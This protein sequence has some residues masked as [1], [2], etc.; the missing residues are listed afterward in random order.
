[1]L[2]Y[3][4]PDIN[5]KQKP[6]KTRTPAFPSVAKFLVFYDLLFSPYAFRLR[7]LVVKKTPAK[8]Q[9]AIP[10]LKGIMGLKNLVSVIFEHQ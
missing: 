6:K 8:N 2:K 4:L 7:A 9:L 3:I 1:L 10:Q 5:K